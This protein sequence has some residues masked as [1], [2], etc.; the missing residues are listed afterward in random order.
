[1]RLISVGG[2]E[3][4]KDA[5]GF[6]VKIYMI[7]KNRNDLIWHNECEEAA[8]LGWGWCVHD[9]F[10]NFI[11]AGVTWDTGTLSVIEAEALALKEAIRGAIDLYLDNV[12]FKSD[13]H[14]VVQV[15]QSNHNG[16]SEFNFIIK[17]IIRM[18]HVFPNFE[19]KFIKRQVN[20][21]AHSLAREANS[22]SRHS[23][24]NLIPPYIEQHLINELY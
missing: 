14:R 7:W 13:S 15:I 1:M 19:L 22:W 3:D 23:V 20:S 8:K 10:R 24:F 17:F 16:G 21:V 11:I 2:K 9:N 6:A 5:D 4:M 12:I 18:L